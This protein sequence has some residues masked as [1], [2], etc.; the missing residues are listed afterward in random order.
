MPSSS[1]LLSNIDR[2]NSQIHRKRKNFESERKAHRSNFYKSI[3]RNE[4]SADAMID[5]VSRKR[6]DQNNLI[7]P[8]WN[9]N[10]VQHVDIQKR[11]FH[12]HNNPANFS[13]S[14]PQSKEDE[15]YSR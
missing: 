7:N 8:K 15:F 6:N 14:V 11:L 13:M 3:I 2:N 9:K 12:D 5:S 10:L 4:R 1:F